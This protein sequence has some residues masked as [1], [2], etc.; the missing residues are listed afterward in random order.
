MLFHPPKKPGPRPEIMSD[1]ERAK[2]RRDYEIKYYSK[3]KREFFIRSTASRLANKILV[4]SRYGTFCQC[5]GESEVDFLTIDH[6]NGKGSEHRR[7]LGMRTIYRWLIRNNFPSG[8]RTLCMNC[9]FA[10]GMYGQ[11]PHGRKK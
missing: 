11:C 7:E 8:F 2:R 3:N 4:L 5:C 6:I 1:E 10:N 9:N